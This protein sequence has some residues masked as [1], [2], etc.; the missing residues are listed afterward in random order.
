MVAQPPYLADVELPLRATTRRGELVRIRSLEP[1]E[2]VP[3]SSSEYSQWGVL[4]LAF[5]RDEHGRAM[6][7]ILIGDGDD[8]TWWPVGDMTWRAQLYGPNLASRAMNLGLSLHLEARGRGIGTVAQSLLAT[9]LHRAGVHR[10]EA[11]SDPGNAGE[12]QAL[13]RAGFRRE[14][15]L[16]GAQVRA[17]GRHDLVLWSCLPGEPAIAPE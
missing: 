10:V 5:E 2:A 9:A 3:D 6:I 14:G 4:D 1:G 12:Q 15:V 8:A 7:E 16:R 11:A 13:D 17:N